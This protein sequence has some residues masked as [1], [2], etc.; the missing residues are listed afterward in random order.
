MDDK[1]TC[2]DC[3]GKQQKG[4]TCIGEGCKDKEHEHGGEKASACQACSCPC[5]EHKEHAHA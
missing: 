2:G 3:S 1:N 4:H 5:D